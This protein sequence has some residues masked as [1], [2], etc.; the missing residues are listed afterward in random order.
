LTTLDAR[1]GAQEG[2]GRADRSVLTYTYKACIPKFHCLSNE[3]TLLVHVMQLYLSHLACKRNF[4]TKGKP[5][6]IKYT[7]ETNEYSTPA[8]VRFS[9][10]S[11]GTP[12]TA[13]ASTFVDEINDGQVRFQRRKGGIPKHNTAM[14]RSR[15]KDKHPPRGW[16]SRDKHPP[17]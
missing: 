3:D 1:T 15:T 10:G 7:T 5:P 13:S 17:L 2:R 6:K 9:D 12:S 11:G 8:T 14:G 4:T 16:K